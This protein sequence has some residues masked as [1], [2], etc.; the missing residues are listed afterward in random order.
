MITM[1]TSNV[2]GESELDFD[3]D[4]RRRGR[5]SATISHVLP[6]LE[7]DVVLDAHHDFGHACKLRAAQDSVEACP[8]VF[9]RVVQFPAED[10]IG[11]GLDDECVEV[12]GKRARIEQVQERVH[13]TRL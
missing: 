1:S 11:R 9:V 4:E 10:V 7:A 13:V 6:L 3:R 2:L 12:G 5:A 8:V